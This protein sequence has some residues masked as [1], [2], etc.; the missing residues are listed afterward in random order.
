MVIRVAQVLALGLLLFGC[1]TTRVEQGVFYS[2][3]GYQVKLPQDGWRIQP[4]GKADLELRRDAPPG[5]MLVDAT[6]E[7][8][9]LGRTLP[10]LARHLTF[11]LSERVTVENTTEAVAGRQAAHAVVR[12]SLDGSPVAVEAFVFKGPRCVHDF[13]YVAPAEEFEAGR[14]DFR[15]LVESFTGETR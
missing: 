14:R 2:G 5:G 6:C 1:S 12:G 10:V 8:N 4:G 13:L 7:G 15:A 9:E 3:K 11:G